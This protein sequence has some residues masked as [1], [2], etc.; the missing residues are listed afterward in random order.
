MSEKQ[1]KLV[2]S[3]LS[4]SYEMSEAY[5]QRLIGVAYGLE[6]SQGLGMVPAPQDI[7]KADAKR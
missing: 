4:D 6:I 3:I 7:E 2:E 1:K 5:R